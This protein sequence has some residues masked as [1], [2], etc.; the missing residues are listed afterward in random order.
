[1][2]VLDSTGVERIAWSGVFISVQPRIRLGRSFDPR[3]PRSR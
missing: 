1:M 3:A 2:I